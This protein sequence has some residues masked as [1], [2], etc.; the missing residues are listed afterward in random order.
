M[1]RRK[2]VLSSYMAVPVIV[3]NGPVGVGKSSVLGEVSDLLAEAGMAHC[4]LDLDALSQTFAPGMDDSYNLRL[5]V[6][7]LRAVWA[8]AAR[9]GAERLVLAS[10]I[11]SDAELRMMMDAVPDAEAFTCRLR[12]P[13]EVLH[14]RL[15]RRE[16]GSALDWHLHRAGELAEILED[17]GV[18]DVVVDTSDRPLRDIGIEILEAADWLPQP[19]H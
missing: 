12:A 15:R 7:N 10:V 16:I 3:I 18:G 9:V 19:R 11:E 17:G 8:N 5:A 4:S 6:Q 2:S 1:H 13:V 14:E